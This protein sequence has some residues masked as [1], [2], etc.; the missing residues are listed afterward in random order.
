MS[1]SEYF[2]H[3]SSPCEILKH[4]LTSRFVHVDH[5][6]MQGFKLQIFRQKCSFSSFIIIFFSAYVCQMTDLELILNI[7][8]YLQKI[9]INIVKSISP[10]IDKQFF[11]I[12]LYFLICLH[13]LIGLGTRSCIF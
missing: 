9:F 4:T 6:G 7:L 5:G 11:L 10:L 12:S 3:I 1:Y 2:V 8:E 13:T